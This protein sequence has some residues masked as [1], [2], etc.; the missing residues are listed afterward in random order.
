MSALTIP[1]SPHGSYRRCDPLS[2]A[3]KTAASGMDAQTKR[4]QIISE[5]LA[6]IHTTAPDPH[7]D[8]YRRRVVR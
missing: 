3:K 6:N 4:L 7:S 5:N 2:R 1:I 8:P